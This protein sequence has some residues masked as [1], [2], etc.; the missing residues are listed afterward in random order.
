MA[1]AVAHVDVLIPWMIGLVKKGGKL[2]LYKEKKLQEASHAYRQAGSKFQDN[3]Y[4]ALQK[5][6]QKYRLTIE[7][8]HNYRLFDADPAARHSAQ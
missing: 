1:R 5:L 4:I 8:E 7:K 2:V 6:C 3:E